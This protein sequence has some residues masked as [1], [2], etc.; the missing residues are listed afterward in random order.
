MQPVTH[1]LIHINFIGKYTMPAFSKFAFSK[2]ASKLDVLGVPNKT[3]SAS[4]Q[5]R[6]L[7]NNAKEKKRGKETSESGLL[8]GG[9][10]KNTHKKKKMRI[11]KYIKAPFFFHLFS[12][13]FPHII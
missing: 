12:F 11:K 1:G 10:G 5:K 2:Y 6:T 13:L 7:E 9:R 4:E 3:V 8:E